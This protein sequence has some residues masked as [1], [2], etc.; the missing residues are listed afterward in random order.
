MRFL[1]LQFEKVR[2]GYAYL[3]AH[4]YTTVAGTLVF[5][6]ILS[7][8]PLAFWVSLLFGNTGLNTEEIL[9]LELFG[10][11]KDL[12]VFLLDNAEEAQSK[13]GILFLVTTIWSGS[14]FFYHLRK[15]GEMIYSH[16]RYGRG[17]RV[18][19]SAIVL[20]LLV[21]LFLGIV[22]GI[23]AGVFWI[24]RILPKWIYY[25]VVYTVVLSVGFVVA[26][27]LNAYACPYR[28]PFSK[29]VTGSVLTAVAWMIASIAFNIY[30]SFSNYEKLYGALS[31]VIVF[32]LWLY[33]MMICFTSGMIY[34]RR[35]ILSKDGTK[36]TDTYSKI[37]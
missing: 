26:W 18:R 2:K 5:F 12:L 28:A 27:V 13:A 8:V 34:N 25:P 36:K 17:L 35:R 31:L 30:L 11:A 16:K 15:S 6:L 22:G 1:K 33:W 10:W 20:A 14:A 32:L 4:K 21:V 29:Y 9:S 7:V 24:A 3:S 37:Q 19:I 23:L